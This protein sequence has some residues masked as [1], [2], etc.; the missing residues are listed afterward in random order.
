MHKCKSLYSSHIFGYQRNKTN[1]IKIWD[2]SR[3]DPHGGTISRPNSPWSWA[4]TH[5]WNIM[6]LAFP[7]VIRGWTLRPIPKWLLN[8]FTTSTLFSSFSY[9]C[10]WMHFISCQEIRVHKYCTHV[11][12][13]GMNWPSQGELRKLVFLWGL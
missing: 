5:K 3:K 11:H 12:N 7:S 2:L 1:L 10:L 8:D 9:A 6:L 13:S 4:N